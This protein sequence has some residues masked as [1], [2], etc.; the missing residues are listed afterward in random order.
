MSAPLISIGFLRLVSSMKTSSLLALLSTTTAGYAEMQVVPERFPVDRYAKLKA[1]APFAVA[2]KDDKPTD[3]PTIG[4]AEPLY[5]SGAYKITEN[6]AEKDWVYIN[7]KSDPSGGFQLFGSDPNA[8]G[9]QIV[10][11]DWHPENPSKTVVQL[12]KGTEFATLKRDE[13]AFVA[14][15]VPVTPQGVRPGQTGG[16]NVPG[17]PQPGG[18]AIPNA[19]GAIRQPVTSGNRGPAI[20]RPSGANA[21]PVPQPTLPQ[22]APG[23]VQPQGSDRRRIRVINAPR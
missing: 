2:T 18:A 14:P 21:V 16:R 12:K 23:A 5:L 19:A 4:W 9:I 6:G 3:E 13:A 22:A 11:L 15:P 10:K 7:H 20:P 8:Q 17:Q 1:D